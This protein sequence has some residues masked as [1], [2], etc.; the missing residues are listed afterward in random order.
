MEEKRRLS[1]NRYH[2]ATSES[3]HGMQSDDTRIAGRNAVL[4]A[5]KAGRA[6]DAVYVASGEKRGSILHILSLCREKRI[7]IKE[8]APKKLDFMVP[9]VSHQGIVA[10][11]ASIEYSSLEKILAYAVE[12][13]QP[14]FVVVADEIEDPHNLGAIIRSAEAAGAH[15][16][17]IPKRRGVQVTP[18]VRKSAAGACEYM[19]IARVDNL[20]SAMESLKEHGLWIYGADMD[21]TP[22]CRTDLTGSLALVIGSEGRGMARLVKEHCDG[23]LSLPMNGKVNSLNASVA[24]GILLFEAARQRLGIQAICKG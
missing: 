20:V 2:D 16:V 22:W 9:G 13:G 1:S 6:L 3:E 15:G 11:A 7:P 21:G 8:A 5:L 18:I 12:R 14:P 23:I 24:A 17:I 19:P 10:V 4:E